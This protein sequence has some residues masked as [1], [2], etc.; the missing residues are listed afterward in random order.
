VN[1]WPVASAPGSDKRVGPL[2]YGRGSDHFWGRSLTVAVLILGRSL[3]VAVLII[4]WGRSLT[5]AVLMG[6]AWGCFL[7][8]AVLIILADLSLGLRPRV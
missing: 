2:P 6:F 1:S 8:V 3:T 4:F 7:A 5:V